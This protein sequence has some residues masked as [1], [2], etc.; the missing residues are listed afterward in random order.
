[1]LIEGVE[2]YGQTAGTASQGSCQQFARQFVEDKSKPA[3]QVCGTSTKVKVYLRNRC[4]DYH[5]YTEEIGTCDSGADSSSCVTASPA[6]QSWMADA[7]SY[8]IVSC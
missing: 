7:Q 2:I 8:E 4:E 6:T 1:M 3:V 5:H